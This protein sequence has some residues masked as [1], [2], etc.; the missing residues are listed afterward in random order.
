MFPGGERQGGVG[1]KIGFGIPFFGRVFEVLLNVCQADFPEELVAVE[2]GAD[3]DEEVYRFPRL[4]REG[5]DVEF[6]RFRMDRGRAEQADTGAHDKSTDAVARFRLVGEFRADREG[7]GAGGGP[8]TDRGVIFIVAGVASGG[9]EI[10]PP[11]LRIRHG[12]ASLPGTPGEMRQRGEGGDAPGRFVD[13]P[14]AVAPVG[15]GGRGGRQ[16]RI[17][18]RLDQNEGLGQF[19][20]GGIALQDRAEKGADPVGRGGH[21]RDR[22]GDGPAA[23]EDKGIVEK[24]E[25][26]LRHGRLVALR[27]VEIGIGKVEDT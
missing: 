15:G 18:G 25:G 17:S 13:G 22:S 11:E 8:A 2:A 4:D 24:K 16:V 20:V 9:V 5:C 7:H 23:V 10:D 3:V 6:D 21:C 19:G 1:G 26:L 27:D 12:G 14:V